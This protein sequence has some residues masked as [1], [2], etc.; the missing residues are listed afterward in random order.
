MQ[1]EVLGI[2]IY[3]HRDL[4]T[5]LSGFNVAYNG[6]RQRV[7]KGRSPEMVLRERLA[8]KPELANTHANPPD[9]GALPRA[10]HAIASAKNVSHPDI[11]DWNKPSLRRRAA[12]PSRSGARLI[13]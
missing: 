7:L 11:R 2:T 8:A 6:R 13:I 4:E 5:V 12:L 1:R 9:P 3:R 10:L